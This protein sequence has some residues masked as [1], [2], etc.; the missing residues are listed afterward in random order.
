L[1]EIFR[2]FAN[3]LFPELPH[4]LT[5]A[6]HP[7]GFKCSVAGSYAYDSSQKDIRAVKVILK[8]NFLSF[9]KMVFGSVLASTL[10]TQF[11]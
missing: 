10:A 3:R 11:L 4:F 2:I 7:T 9:M 1:G 6:C 5:L 8:I